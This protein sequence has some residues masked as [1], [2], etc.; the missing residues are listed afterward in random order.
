MFDIKWIR[1]NPESFDAGL[2][3]RGIAPMAERLI[4]L[5]KSRREARTRAQELRPSAIPS[6]GKSGG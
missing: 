1:Q 2:A 5:D 6:P 3:G 4:A